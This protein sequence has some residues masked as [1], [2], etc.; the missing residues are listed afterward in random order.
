MLFGDFWQLPP[1][2]DVH[3]MG[4]TFRGHALC[5]SKMQ[6][7]LSIFWADGCECLNGLTELQVNKRSG[8]DK[9]LSIVVDECRNGDLHWDNYNF[10]H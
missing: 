5:A 8:D 4:N 10:L 6:R 2:V 3:L 7:I 9:W 1:V